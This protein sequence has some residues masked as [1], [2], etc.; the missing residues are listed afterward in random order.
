MNLNSLAQ[1]LVKES[2]GGDGAADAARVRAVC[3]YIQTQTPK[4]ETLKLLRKYK[5]LMESVLSRRNC[6][7][8]FAG[9]LDSAEL[10][11]LKR[12][13]AERAGVNVSEVCA[14]EN[15]DLIAGVRLICGDNVWENSARADLDGLNRAI[16]GEQS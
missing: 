8:E 9:N 5:A 2:F 16:R 3:E 15:K 12:F 7:V 6:R 14:Q 10:D 11:R 13:L 4:T 1:I